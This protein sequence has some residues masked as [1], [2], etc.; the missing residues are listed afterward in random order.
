MKIVLFPIMRAALSGRRSPSAISSVRMLLQECHRV[1]IAGPDPMLSGQPLRNHGPYSV[2][3]RLV[4]VIPEVCR[5]APD[6]AGTDSHGR[7]DLP[8]MSLTVKG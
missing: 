8:K 6:F 2:F 7:M 4:H 5:V 1:V 3:G